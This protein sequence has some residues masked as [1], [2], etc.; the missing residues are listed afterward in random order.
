MPPVFPGE[1]ADSL[2][3]LADKLGLDADVFMQT[4][5][6]YNQ[7]CKPG[8]FDHTKLDDCHTEGLLPAK[9]HWALPLDKPTFYGYALR[10]G[11]TFTYQ[12]LFTDE[13]AAVRFPDQP[14][15]NL[16]MEGGMMGR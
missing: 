8:T 11:V 13:T 16:I 4:L 2:P 6:S 10:P 12:G 5:N 14:S 3:D 7:A 1:Q 15:Q 9:T